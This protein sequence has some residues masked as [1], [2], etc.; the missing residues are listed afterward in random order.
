MKTKTMPVFYL[1]TKPLP[2]FNMAASPT[3]VTSINYSMA[4]LILK[5]DLKSEFDSI[6]SEFNYYF[7]II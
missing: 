7:M 6:V 3:S 4:W 2:S 1:Q 5:N